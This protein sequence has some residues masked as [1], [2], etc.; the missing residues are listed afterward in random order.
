MN[1]PE[2]KKVG[3]ENGYSIVVWMFFGAFK[4]SSL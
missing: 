1:F 4:E 2:F 3:F